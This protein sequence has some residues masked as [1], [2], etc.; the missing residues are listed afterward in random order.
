MTAE[1]PAAPG[2]KARKAE[3]SVKF[4]PVEIMR[5]QPR[6]A[7][8]G[9]PK[10]IAATLVVGRE[11]HP[12]EGEEP[13]LRLL[14]TTHPVNDIADAR[15]IIGFYRWRGTI[16][17]LFRTMKTKGF[18]VEALRRQEGGPLER[19][20]AAVLS[21]SIQAMQRVAARQGDAQR[22]LARVFDPD[23]PPALERVWQSLAGKTQKQK[24]PYPHG[25][26]AYAAWVF[27]RLGG[28]TGDYGKPGP[29][30]R[31]RASP[32]STPSSTDG[33]PEMRESSR[34][35]PGG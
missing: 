33:A 18:A 5:P 3:L 21:A 30:V 20:V 27:A 15:R 4:G 31:L 16:E 6:K 2:R 24:N 17:P 34:V 26:L 12:P 14:P 25:S 28:W 7:S 9:L 23:D 13:A 32:S 8:D 10:T 29:I 22:P 35:K 1:L 19:R 11:I